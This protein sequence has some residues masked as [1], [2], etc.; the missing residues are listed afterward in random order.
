MN[1]TI[2][3]LIIFILFQCFS[4]GVFTFTLNDYYIDF[5]TV[6]IGESKY[7]LPANNL[8]IT[9]K[10]DQGSQWG[11][12]ISGTGDMSSGRY[13]IPLNN[14]KWFGT[15]ASSVDNSGTGCFTSNGRYFCK[16]QATSL[17]TTT[18]GG[19]IYNSDT[20][21]DISLNSGTAVYLKFGITIP[22]AQPE[23]TYTTSVL[24][25]MTE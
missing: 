23:G 13:R 9:C 5:G 20:T 18:A 19:L 2:L 12:A 8:V 25:T 10:S 17:T 22:E 14:L 4:W 21:G 15:Y 24:I 16:D 11:L 7:G 3:L 1:K 6:G